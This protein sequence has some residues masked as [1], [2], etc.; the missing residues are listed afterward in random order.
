LLRGDRSESASLVVLAASVYEGRLQD[1]D[2]WLHPRERERLSGLTAEKRRREFLLGRVAAKQAIAVMRPGL[3]GRQVSID[4]GVFQQPVVCSA[5]PCPLGVS[6]THSAGLAGAVAFPSGHP[7]G[8]D[9][10]PIAGSNLSALQSHVNPG[11]LPPATPGS[12]E[13]ERFTRVWTIKESL[14]KVLGCGMMT[15]FSLFTPVD[16]AFAGDGSYRGGFE[17]FPQYRFLSL[18]TP[19]V[20]FALVHPARTSPLAHWPGLLG[21]LADH[22]SEQRA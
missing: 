13:A 6:L 22:S 20:A 2:W 12:S 9:I 4:A 14:S 15:P 3:V 1:V 18:V 19:H 8:I 7:I 5:D 11:D 10:E 21:F 17:H 16:A